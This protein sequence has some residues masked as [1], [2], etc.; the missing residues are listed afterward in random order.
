MLSDPMGGVYKRLSSRMT[1]WSGPA[2]TATRWMARGTSK[3]LREGKTITEI[4]DHLMFGESNIG[5]VGHEGNT[6]AVQMKTATRCGCN[7]V[8]KGTDH[9][10]D[11][12]K[13]CSRSTKCAAHQGIDQAAV[14]ALV[15]SNR[16]SCSPPVVTTVL[17]QR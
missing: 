4:R 2:S 6:R 9:Q 7:G 17:R 16:Y 1:N 13:G 14:P 11:Q 10:G 8:C 5:D 15:S 3:L 12:D